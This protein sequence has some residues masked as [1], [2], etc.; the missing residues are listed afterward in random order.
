MV[1]D[2]DPK[3]FGVK[4]NP[5]KEDAKHSLKTTSS[6]PPGWG[7]EKIGIVDLVGRE[8]GW[9]RGSSS[10]ALGHRNTGKIGFYE[11]ASG[12][13]PI[14]LTGRPGCEFFSGTHEARR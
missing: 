4:I 14:V 9:F 5:Q 10:F 13:A 12:T 3:L 8:G 2:C 11:V 7:N 6:P 1:T